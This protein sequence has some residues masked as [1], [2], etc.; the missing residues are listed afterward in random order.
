M[1]PSREDG[2]RNFEASDESDYELDVDYLIQEDCHEVR[3]ATSGGL[4]KLREPIGQPQTLQM[5]VDHCHAHLRL[6]LLT[7]FH[8]CS[9]EQVDEARTMKQAQKAATASGAK[10]NTGS[11]ATAPTVAAIL[12]KSVQGTHKADKQSQ[13]SSI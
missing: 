11:A 13:L 10:K 1:R 7:L 8:T 12:R 5:C 9:Q 2:G 6:D 4:S 3:W